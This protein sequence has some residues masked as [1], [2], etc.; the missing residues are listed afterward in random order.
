MHAEPPPLPA[1]EFD[2]TLEPG[3]PE[4]AEV[5]WGCGSAGI[6]VNGK[7]LS[8]RDS[9]VDVESTDWVQL[10]IDSSGSEGPVY[11]FYGL[12]E[13]MGDATQAKYTVIHYKGS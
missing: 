8:A 7:D 10:R 2:G 5:A 3:V 12:L 9:L 4:A 1:P 13:L 6:R 11:Y